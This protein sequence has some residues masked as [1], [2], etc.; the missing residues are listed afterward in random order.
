MMTE[1]SREKE[2]IEDAGE[3]TQWQKRCPYEGSEE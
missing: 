3:R 2:Q 1:P